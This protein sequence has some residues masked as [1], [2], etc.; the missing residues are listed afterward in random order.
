MD[1]QAETLAL[2]KVLILDE[3]R[4]LVPV[5][6]S[7]CDRSHLLA[8]MGRRA[9]ASA[10]L[11]ANVDLGGILLSERY[12]WSPQETADL[13]QELHALRPEVPIILRREHE[14]TLDGLPDGLRTACSG[15]YV[16]SDL[17]TL[18]AAIDAHVFTLHYP[19]AL[20][21]GIAEISERVLT[22]EFGGFSL[23]PAMPLIVHDQ[24][25]F[26]ELFSLIPL[27]S[28]WCRGY[29]LL[30]TE[31]SEMLKLLDFGSASAGGASIDALKDRLREATNLIWGLFKNRYANDRQASAPS[32]VQ[33]PL[34][35]NLREK[36]VSFGASNTHLCMRYRL[37]DE[38]R[39]L[40]LWI[41]ARFVF[42]LTWAPQDFCETVAVP[43]D[44]AGVAAG[45][46]EYF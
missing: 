13:A 23:S 31:E 24:V 46:L 36:S 19:K 33:V 10:L 42:N 44:A 2:S 18:L 12:G 14:A 27:E 8:I 32:N 4:T 1:E 5:I 11:R 38:A 20:L 7:F 37:S 25:S 39:D 41:C 16:A 40:S 35:F 30:Q 34:V 17:D 45:G 22:S 21:R 28:H 6:K 3:S 43:D 26:G 29:L 9:P 15:A